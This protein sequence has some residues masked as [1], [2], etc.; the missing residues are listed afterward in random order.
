LRKKGLRRSTSAQ[1]WRAKKRKKK[2]R[3]FTGGQVRFVYLDRRR[4]E[5]SLET[6]GYFLRGRAVKR[7]NSPNQLKQ[8]PALLSP[9]VGRGMK[10]NV[11]RKES[12]PCFRVGV[13][14]R[15]SFQE[16]FWEQRK[17]LST[18]TRRGGNLPKVEKPI[19]GKGGHK[20][21]NPQR[22][23]A[24]EA[25]AFPDFSHH[26]KKRGTGTGYFLPKKS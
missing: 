17:N 11:Y 13:A 9:S 16:L 22:E 18:H 14:E 1:G 5:G 8:V 3:G 20:E 21:S 24:M 19:L 23:A 25:P 15:R 4:R 10:G 2:Q 6:K 26:S 12:L 7:K